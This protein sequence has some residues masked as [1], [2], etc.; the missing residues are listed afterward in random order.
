MALHGSPLGDGPLGDAALCALCSCCV[1]PAY[2]A[3]LV[4]HAGTSQPS[5]PAF[6]VRL[7]LIGDAWGVET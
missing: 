3:D 4:V 7:A 2:A 6:A 1:A 5:S